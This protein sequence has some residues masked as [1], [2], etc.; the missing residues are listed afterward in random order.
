MG[1]ERVP[2]P[3]GVGFVC[4]R[5]RQ[6][7]PRCSGCGSTRTVALCDFPLRG[8]KAG[9]TCDRPLCRACATALPAEL[10][11]QMG[12]EVPEGGFDVCRAHGAE[13]MHW[14]KTRPHLPL[15]LPAAA[16]QWLVDIA[17]TASALGLEQ[18]AGLVAE[19]RDQLH[20]DMQHAPKMLGLTRARVLAALRAR[21]RRPDPTAR[22]AAA[23]SARVH[24]AVMQ[25]LLPWGTAI[26]S[27]RT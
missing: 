17:A 19:V 16:R 25:L 21:H 24:L 23:S 18:T 15:V 20:H 2:F 22:A 13:V 12:A 1:C 7:G 3:G 5:G 9:K 10:V 14:A 27:R 26:S 11:V 4:S 6:A 8:P